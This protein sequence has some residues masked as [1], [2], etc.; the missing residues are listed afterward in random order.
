MIFDT[1]DN[2]SWWLRII[3]VAL[4]IAILVTGSLVVA[5]D[6]YFGRM[7][8]GQYVANQGADIDSATITEAPFI[9]DED[10]PFS[11]EEPDGDG[12]VS[13]IRPSSLNNLQSNIKNWINNGEPVRDNDV[14]NILYICM[15]NND[16]C[17]N[18]QALNVN[19]R[20]DAM[21]IISV[22]KRT[23]TIT[24]ASILR[25]QYS[26]VVANGKGTYTKFHHALGKGGPEKQIE[27]IERY[28]KV[29]IDNY[30]L[31]N[32][33]S[34]PKVIDALG[35]VTIEVDKNEASYLKNQCGWR[36][37]AEPQTINVD[38]GHALTY[39]R[40]RKGATG[41]D[42]A[43]VGRQQ[44]VIMTLMGKVKEYSVSQMIS[45]V[46]EVIPYVRT[47][48]SSSDILAYALTALSEGW[49][50]YDI[51]Q[52]TLPD[53]D[54]ASGFTNSADGGWY[55]K[56]DYPVSAQ[57]LQMALFGRTNIVLDP[58]RKSWIK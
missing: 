27:M 55:W 48:L 47:G 42:N 49:L 32:F 12:A 4:S 51:K 20:A 2:V 50:K 38:G 16:E 1:R 33:E 39:M 13:T 15:E 31:V 52:V 11:T 56:V 45:A 9:P 41:G 5:W 28:Y 22:N 53:D 43:R 36:I 44:K 10:E 24:L 35:G 30:V 14:T 3:A 57:K 8:D 54:C 7:S 29:V 21:C 37:D 25:D 18:P 26:Y 6:A 23:R 17:G 46:N 34:L 58:N 40:I 19:G